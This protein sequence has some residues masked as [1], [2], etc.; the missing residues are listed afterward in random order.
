MT[1]AFS[2]WFLIAEFNVYRNYIAKNLCENRYRPGLHC[3]GKCV[4]M[5]KMRPGK[6]SLQRPEILN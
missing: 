5:K 6:T 1:Q 4:F 2:K 3:N